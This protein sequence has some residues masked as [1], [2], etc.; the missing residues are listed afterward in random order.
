MTDQGLLLH[1]RL[2]IVSTARS[3]QSCVVAGHV[4]AEHRGG[5]HPVKSQ[6]VV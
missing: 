3:A 1:L 6:L 4:A 2:W 5:L